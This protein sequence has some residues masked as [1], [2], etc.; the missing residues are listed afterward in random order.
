MHFKT[1]DKILPIG[2]EVLEFGL[3]KR[4]GNGLNTLVLQDPWIPGVQPDE[5]RRSCQ[6]I[7]P[8]CRVIDFISES[9][10]WNRTELFRFFPAQIASLICGIPIGGPLVIDSWFWHPDPG[11]SFSVRSGYK[12][13]RSRKLSD[14]S[15]SNQPSQLNQRGLDVASACPICFSEDELVFHALLG[16][17]NLGNL[18][19]NS[20]IPFVG[21]SS[22]EMQ[23]A[24]WFDFALHH[25]SSDQFHLF[26]FIC[27]LV[28]NCRNEV[29]LKLNTLPLSQLLPKAKDMWKEVS[30][31]VSRPATSWIC[32]LR[33]VKW[34]A[35]PIHFMKL[36]IDAS[37]CGVVAGSGCVFRNESGRVLAAKA[38][39]I[40][41]MASVAELEAMAVLQGLQMAKD[42][43]ILKVF[44]EGDNQWVMGKLCSP[45]GCLSPIGSIFDCI[46]SFCSHFSV[47]QFGWV[48]REANKVAHK[49]AQVGCTLELDHVWLEDSPAVIAAELACDG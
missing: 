42:L 20:E 4:L 49:L 1:N 35:P 45:H 10:Q 32:D 23:F 39:R 11:G 28:W 12:E 22:G 15:T 5:L 7:D 31:A 2:R 48:P 17:E 47:V 13:L 30:E 26:A 43:G 40:P 36:N 9:W 25:W 3:R 6:S 18:W 29:R 14:I 46:R 24:E 8:S 38:A 33:S 34:K 41:V 44:V 21:E 19:A 27:Y 37:L 16:C